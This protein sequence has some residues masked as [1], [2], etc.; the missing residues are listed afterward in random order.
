MDNATA[1]EE[2]ATKA[3]TKCG[4][5]KPLSE[6]ST[7]RG[8][9]D[10][11]VPECKPCAVARMRTYVEKN[12]EKRTVYLKAYYEA[13]REAIAEKNSEYYH[14]NA[15]R[16]KA[17]TAA[18]YRSSKAFGDALLAEAKQMTEMDRHVFAE[19]LLLFA[20]VKPA[21]RNVLHC[22]PALDGFISAYTE[23]WLE[24]A[25]RDPYPIAA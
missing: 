4:E 20:Q 11:K 15:P 10:G 2:L 23:E 24:Q 16:I 12:R 17:R 9:K 18:M 14:R 5:K 1:S 6:F 25:T 22:H 3:C 7:D 19:K 21:Y 13:N 8:K